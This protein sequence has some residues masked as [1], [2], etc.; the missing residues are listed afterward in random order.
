MI[1]RV[2]QYAIDIVNG[3]YDDVIG[4]SERKACQR[5]I[6]DLEKSKS[7]P[8]K[9]YFNVDESEKIIDFAETLTIAEGE[10][11]QSVVC[12]PFQCFI[13][14]SLNGWR[15]KEND[16]RRFRKSYIELARQNGKSFINGILAAFYGNFSDYKYGQI[17]LT[18]T[19]Q[20]QSK[21][22][23]NEIAKFIRSDVELEELFKITEHNNTITCLLTNSVIKALSGDTKSFDGFRPYLGI[24]DEYHAHKTNQMYKLL[25]DGTK[26]LKSCLISVITT[27]GFNLKSPCYE[28]YKH[29]KKILDGVFEDDSQFVYICEPNEND[30]WFVKN[31][32]LKANP[33]LRDDKIALENLLS[34]AK[35]AKEMGGNDLRDYI[36]KQLNLW[37]Q[38]GNI[39]YINDISKW[40]ACGSERTLADFRGYNCYVGLD[41]SSG[42][43]LTSIAIVIPF[44]LDGQKKYYIFSHSYMPAKR[45]QEHIESDSYPYDLWHKQGLITITETLQGIKTDYQ[46][47]L[48]DLQRYVDEYDLKIKMICYDP[49]NASAF[50]GDLEALGF[51]CMCI[52]QTSK[53]LNDAT[54][55]L[56]LEIYAGNVEFDK[57]NQLLTASMASATVI[58]NPKYKEITISK[59]V[60]TDRIDP[61]DA[62]IDAWK[63]AMQD[64]QVYSNDDMLE[65]YFKELERNGF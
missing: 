26:K 42:G 19:K 7:A 17:Y 21:I 14:G 55:D 38:A 43:D 48:A 1:D 36:V 16:Y 33:L 22:V 32:I 40:N 63:M 44:I 23:F 27:A 51:D 53:V 31:T 9:Y 34:V 52:T 60:D 8:Y 65:D 4:E 58:K 62:V 64:D 6:D 30:D 45:L 2:T 3:V 12:K 54:Q 35:T 39:T 25:E 61:I 18:A 59:D 15:T 57:N 10:E 47:I 28:L 13:L 24:V 5:H 46:Y 29:C 20:D 49:H 50:L 56:R 37:V 11:Q 41:L